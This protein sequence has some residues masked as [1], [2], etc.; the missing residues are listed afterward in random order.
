M[1]TVTVK[2]IF[3][4]DVDDVA[5]Y[6]RGILNRDHDVYNLTADAEICVTED[7]E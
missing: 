1:K 4:E 6:V 2:F 7:G 3:D 5:E